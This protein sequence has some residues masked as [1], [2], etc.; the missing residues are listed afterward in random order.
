LTVK[1]GTGRIIEY[2][3]PGVE[4]LSCTGMATICNMGAEVGATTSLF[5]YTEKMSQYLKATKRSDQAQLA[6]LYGEFLRPDKDAKYEEVIEIDLSTLEPHIN[7]PSTPG[8]VK[9]E[10]NLL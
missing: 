9:F 5:P 10:Q 8:M 3:G 7:G 6:D 1:G 2:F 4:T